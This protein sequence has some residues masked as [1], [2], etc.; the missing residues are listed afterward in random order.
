MTNEER[1]ELTTMVER[2]YNEYRSGA[3]SWSGVYHG[4]LFISIIAS[5]VATLFLKLEILKNTYQ[6]DIAASLAL[7]AAI[8]TAMTAEGGFNRKWRANRVS[9][10]LTEQLRTDTSDPAIDGAQIR[11]R[12]N[13]IIRRHDEGIIGPEHK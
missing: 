10:S 12:L 4:C 6:S 5:A 7:L 1:A 8:L 13:E 2:K 9:R 3:K 11:K